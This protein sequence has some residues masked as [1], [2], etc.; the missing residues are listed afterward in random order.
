MA[1]FGDV[2]TRRMLRL[3]KWLRRTKGVAVG[4]GGRHNIKVTVI[5]RGESYPL[6]TS[7]SIVNKHIVQDFMEWLVKMEICTKE[8][9]KDR[10]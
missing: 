2:K 1:G 9:F 7:H 10:L 3:V 5:H 6:P 4:Q 8:E